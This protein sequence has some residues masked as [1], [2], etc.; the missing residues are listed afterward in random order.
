MYLLWAIAKIKRDKKYLTPLSWNDFK[1]IK[2][3]FNLISVLVRDSNNIKAKSRA[4]NYDND[5]IQSDLLYFKS[6]YEV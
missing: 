4:I 3:D 2:S 5:D 6:K 1:Y